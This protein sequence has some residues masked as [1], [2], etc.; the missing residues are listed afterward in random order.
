MSFDVTAALS[1]LTEADAR[2]YIIE[3]QCDPDQ[4]NLAHVGVGWVVIDPKPKP[5]LWPKL[6]SAQSPRGLASESK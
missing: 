5:E 4:N 2:A 1:F 6:D 3:H